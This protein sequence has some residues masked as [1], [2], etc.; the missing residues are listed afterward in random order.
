[1]NYSPEIIF[2]KS[3]HHEMEQYTVWRISYKQKKSVFVKWSSFYKGDYERVLKSQSQDK[4][5]REHLKITATLEGSD[6]IAP[7]LEE[8]TAIFQNGHTWLMALTIKC[9]EKAKK[10]KGKKRKQEFMKI[11]REVK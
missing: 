4:L 2:L 8:F 6:S 5:Q 10:E 9:K 7:T 11:S 3:E 1:M